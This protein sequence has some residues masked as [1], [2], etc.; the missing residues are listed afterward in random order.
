MWPGAAVSGW[1]FAHPDAR[2]FAVAKIQQDQLQDYAARKGWS[3]DQAEKW[4]APNLQ[5]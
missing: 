3:I 2:Y 5:D 1:Y 4:L